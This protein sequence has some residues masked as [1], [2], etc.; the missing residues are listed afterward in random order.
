MEN[1]CK[2]N[3]IF[4]KPRSDTGCFSQGPSR[5]DAGLAASQEKPTHR[6]PVGCCVL[7]RTPK[8]WGAPGRHRPSR[9]RQLMGDMAQPGKKPTKINKT[10]TNRQREGRSEHTGEEG[11]GWGCFPGGSTANAPPVPTRAAGV[12]RLDKTI[13]VLFFSRNPRTLL[14]FH[15][16]G[17]RSSPS[18][19]APAMPAPGRLG[20]SPPRLGSK[21]PPPPAHIWGHQHQC[22]GSALQRGVP[23]DCHPPRLPSRSGHGDATILAVRP[24]QMPSAARAGEL[25][26]AVPCPCAWVPA[27]PP[28]RPDGVGVTRQRSW[29]AAG[30]LLP[31]GLPASGGRGLLSCP[32]SGDSASLR[33][34]NP[35]SSL[36][37]EPSGC[38]EAR[39]APAQCS[40][41][42]RSQP[43]HPQP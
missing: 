19:P 14:L 12:G 7:G 43:R 34:G 32:G 18:P 26:L 9:P 20:K 25:S 2:N 11:P 23:D 39:L 3:R 28:S 29:D 6:H 41:T 24:P 36:E 38:G 4:L 22:G 15:P 42:P 33:P 16:R 1:C 31:P 13:L 40:G 27:S 37:Q 17:G 35:H 10:E 21:R 30:T 5:C 8:K